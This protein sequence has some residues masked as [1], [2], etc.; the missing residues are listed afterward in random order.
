M[1]FLVPAAPPLVSQSSPAS[2][3]QNESVVVTR[4]RPY[5]AEMK[6]REYPEREE[7][8]HACCVH[9]DSTREERQRKDCAHDSSTM[10]E[11]QRE[12][13]GR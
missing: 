2:S 1:I 13:T 10:K 12:D 8:V 11:R 6:E 7:V 3:S 5:A 9:D 4:A